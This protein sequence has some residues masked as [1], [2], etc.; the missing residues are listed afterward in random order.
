MK[1]KNAK[2]NTHL[3]KVRGMFCVD[4][5][6]YRGEIEARFSSDRIGETLSL[7]TGNLIVI[8]PFEE[9]EDLVEETRA[10]NMK[11]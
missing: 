10:E 9:I 3:K 5:R 7:A 8:V 6:A 2:T 4:D 11:S 1:E